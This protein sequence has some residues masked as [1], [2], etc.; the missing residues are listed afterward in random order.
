[1]GERILTE[2]FVYLPCDRTFPDYYSMIKQPISLT[3][4]Q[5]KIVDAKVGQNLI[6]NNFK[7]F[8]I[9]FTSIF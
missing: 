1:M 7:H 8:L 5:N 3:C 4:I 6:L 2:P 9:N